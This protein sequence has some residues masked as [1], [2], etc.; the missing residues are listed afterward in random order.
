MQETKSS[1]N[2]MEAALSAAREA[3]ARGEIPIGAVI[4]DSRT[5]QIIATAGNQTRADLDP[6]LHAEM[7]AIRAAC[8]TLGQERLTECD[9]Y[10]T[11][12]PCAM[13]AAAISFARLRRLYY[14]APDPK[15]GAVDHGPRFFESSTCHHRPEIYGGIAERE[16][17]ALLKQFFETRRDEKAVQ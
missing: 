2:F 9:I 16:A 10:I 12:E 5:G 17:G 7:L 1:Q 3:G 4:V 8:T 11:L 15:G 13:C 14:G 6:T